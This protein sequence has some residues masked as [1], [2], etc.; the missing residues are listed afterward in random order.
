MARSVVFRYKGREIDPQQ[1]GRELGVEAAL[2]GRVLQQDDRLIIRTELLDVAH[3]WQLWGAQYNRKLTDIFAVQDD[4]SREMSEKLRLKLTG[5]DQRRMTRRYTESTQAY[6]LYL[7]GRFY[8]NKRTTPTLRRAIEYFQQAINIDPD[9]ALAYVGL[10]DCYALLSLYSALTPREAFP[11]ALAAARRALEI[12][13]TL[14]EAHNTLAV[15][16]V[17]YEWD[18]EVAEKEFERAL[19]LKPGY[20]DAHQRY[21]I[22]LVARGRFEEAIEELRCAQ[23]LD[24]LSLIINTIAG[25]PFYYSRRYDEAIEQYRKTLEMDPN[26]SMA[27]FR[28]G[29][30]YEQKGMYEEAL[31]ELQT[32]KALS[33]DRDVIAALGHLYAV[34]GQRERAMQA[35][36]E[37]EERKKQT[38]VSSYD[39]AIVYAGLNERELAFA[40]LEEACEERSYWLIYLKVDPILDNLRSDPRFADL[41]W[42]VGL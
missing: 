7:K 25:Y 14:A 4:I 39:L 29:L 21:G 31:A 2:F 16:K 30:A 24:P 41:V 26:F 18:W 23:E 8:W 32:S 37:L 33:G 20:P 9:Y 15:I 19:L 12:D 3:G 38:Y 28:L 27:H 22:Y 13:G 17:F 42:R 35:L 36:T 34:T 10:A 1:V 5:E 40:W 6:H 11:K